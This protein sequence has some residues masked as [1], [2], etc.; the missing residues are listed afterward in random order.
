[1]NSGSPHP[2]P[3][4]RP[5]LTLF[6][7][8]E[9]SLCRASIRFVARHVPE[10]EV[11]PV[12]IGSDEAARLT[13]GIP[14]PTPWPDSIAVLDQGAIHF[15]TSALLRVV[16]RMRFPWRLLSLLAPVP[17]TLRDAAY[18]WVAR[19][20]RCVITSRRDPRDAASLR[21]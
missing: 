10:G 21:T 3:S 17:A 7:D 15:F 2:K 11:R 4:N 9:C 6:Y 19:H 8:G 5:P 14:V 1:M 20:R 13:A 18:R 16:R 12:P